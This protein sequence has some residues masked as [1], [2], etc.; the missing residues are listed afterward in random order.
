VYR[1]RRE[2]FSAL[3]LI[4]EL[5]STGVTVWFL[6]FLKLIR[7]PTYS[8]EPVTIFQYIIFLIQNLA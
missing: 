3:N 1:R 5:I 2:R 4:V 6:F 8:D 7:C